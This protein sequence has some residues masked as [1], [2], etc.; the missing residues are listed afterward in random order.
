MKST[1]RWAPIRARTSFLRAPSRG[2]TRLTL[3]CLL[4][5]IGTVV[6]A[7]HAL[8]RA[9]EQATS[10]ATANSSSA[11]A[12]RFPSDIFPDTGNRFAAIKREEL[13][14]AGKKLYDTRGVLDNFGPGAIR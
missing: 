6:V 13:D 7:V 9:P 1:F 2:R 5:M 11:T 3:M 12:A 4:L 8:T 10:G 14:D